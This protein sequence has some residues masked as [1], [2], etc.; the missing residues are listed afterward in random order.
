LRDQSRG[1]PTFSKVATTKKK[2][3]WYFIGC[4]ANSG[5]CGGKLLPKEKDL[6]RGIVDEKSLQTL[7]AINIVLF[8]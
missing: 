2:M 6:I 5:Y 3:K 7:G 1:R 8:L 4:P